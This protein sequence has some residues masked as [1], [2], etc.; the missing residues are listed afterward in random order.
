MHRVVTSYRNG[1]TRPVVEKGPWHPN[2]DAASHWAEI[3]RML[4]YVVEV[5]SQHGLEDDDN[6]ALAD[7][8]SSMA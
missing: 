8:L 1:G 4:G 3:F 2:R 7:A 5:E 6:R